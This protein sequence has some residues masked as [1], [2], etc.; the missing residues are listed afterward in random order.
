MMDKLIYNPLQIEACI[1]RLSKK[2]NAL[3]SWETED[4]VILAPILQG[5]VR[6]FSDISKKLIFDPRIEYIGISSYV[7]TKQKEFN[8]YKMIDPKLVFN[9][10]IWLFDDIADT[11]NTLQFLTQTLKA[12]GAKE[13]KTCVLFKKIHCTFPVDLTGFH[14][15]DEWVFG[16]GMDGENGRGRALNTV[17]QYIDYP[18]IK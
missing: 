1:H 14:I 15:N 6:F 13:V 9:K 8:L 3:Y 12:H 10:T 11:G 16:Y 7:G 18:S 4:N 2:L 17:H 5:A